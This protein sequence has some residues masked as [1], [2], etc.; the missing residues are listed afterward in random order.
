VLICLFAWTPSRM[1]SP[2]SCYPKTGLITSILM[3]WS[4]TSAHYATTGKMQFTTSQ[5]VAAYG[6][7]SSK[8]VITGCLY[9]MNNCTQWSS[10]LSIVL[11]IKLRVQKVNAYLTGVNAHKVIAG[12]EG[13]MLHQCMRNAMPREVMWPA[14]WGSR[15]A[16]A[17]TIQNQSPEWE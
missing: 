10:R 5:Y 2:N 3:Q 6:S 13:W 8:T 15:V 16:T 11:R 7:W 1:R 17:T 4:M 12:R 9:L 14:E